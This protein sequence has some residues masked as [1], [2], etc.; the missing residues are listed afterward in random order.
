MDPLV[1]DMVP[2]VLHV[3]VKNKCWFLREWLEHAWPIELG[4]VRA[5]PVNTG[6]GEAA[7]I[8]GSFSRGALG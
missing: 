8:G 4:T 6:I 3:L 2:L 7:R 5:E 1:L